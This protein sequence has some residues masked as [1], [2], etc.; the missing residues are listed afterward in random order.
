MRG[1][2]L[3]LIA[4]T[5]CAQPPKI[6]FPSDSQDPKQSGGAALL[7]AV[8]PGRVTA[9]DQLGCS[10]ACPQFTGFPREDFGWQLVAVTRGHFLS[11]QSDDAVLWMTGCE[12]HAENWGGTILLTRASQTWEMLWYKAGIDTAQCHKVRLQTGREIL[13]CLGVSGAQ[14]VRVTQ[15]YAEDLLDPK[16]AGMAGDESVFFHLTDDTATC[17][18]NPENESKPE[19]ITRAYIESV[20]FTEVE[21]SV[22]SISVN[23]A[24]GGQ[25]MTPEDVAACLDEQNPTKPHKGL[26]FLPPTKREQLDFVFEGGAYHRSPTVTNRK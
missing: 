6:I 24:Q 1:L 10:G 18:E 15:L 3:L 19:P 9:G 22:A 5:A 23:A 13:V 21:R 14:G 16:P 25:W 11:T 7:E 8:C 17:G 2:L 26:S 20:T 4:A 12:P